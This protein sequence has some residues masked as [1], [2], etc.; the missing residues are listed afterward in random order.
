MWVCLAC[1]VYEICNLKLLDGSILAGLAFVNGY[2]VWLADLDEQEPDLVWE[3]TEV[4]HPHAHEI[5]PTVDKPTDG[6]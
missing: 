3:E 6:S 2:M 1:A 4:T 5:I